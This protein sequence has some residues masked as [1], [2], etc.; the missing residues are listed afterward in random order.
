MEGG[1]GESKQKQTKQQQQQTKINTRERS[2][3]E[4]G[5]G[6]ELVLGQGDGMTK[7]GPLCYCAWCV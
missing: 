6:W 2:L 7:G 4:E 1:V 3:E 5:G